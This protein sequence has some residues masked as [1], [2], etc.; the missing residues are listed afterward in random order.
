MYQIQI[1]GVVNSFCPG[2]FYL[3]KFGHHV[4][5]FLTQQGIHQQHNQELGHAIHKKL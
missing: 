2:F 4:H 1:I 3:K 5:L